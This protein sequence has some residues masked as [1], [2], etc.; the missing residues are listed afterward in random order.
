MQSDRQTH[1]PPL[2]L[3][4]IQILIFG[5]LSYSCTKYISYI[6]IGIDQGRQLISMGIHFET[7]QTYRGRKHFINLLLKLLNY[8]LLV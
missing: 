7:Y 6:H 2:I 8:F 5:V 3:V 4:F 1:S